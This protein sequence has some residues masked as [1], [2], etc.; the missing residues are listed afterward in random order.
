MSAL[1]TT[2][3]ALAAAAP[4]AAL[5]PGLLLNRP[6]Q[7]PEDPLLVVRAPATSRAPRQGHTV[8]QPGPYQRGRNRGVRKHNKRLARNRHRRALKRNKDNKIL[9]SAGALVAQSAEVTR[10]AEDLRRL[11]A[12]DL[13]VGQALAAADRNHNQGGTTRAVPS[14]TSS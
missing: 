7:L 9:W 14:A 13:R 3:L 12:Q 6:R 4:L 10:L 8:P 1:S 2:C 11:V 5:L